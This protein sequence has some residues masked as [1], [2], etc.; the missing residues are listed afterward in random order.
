MHY[1]IEKLAKGGTGICRTEGKTWFVEGALPGEQGEAQ[2]LDDKGRYGRCRAISR[3][4]DSPF[5]NQHD[6]CPL[7]CENKCDGCGFRHVRPE[8]A[9]SLKA[10][11]VYETLIHSARL[12]EMPY[13]C[14]GLDQN[15]L[16]HARTRA[17][18]HIDH[19]RMGF[20]LRESHTVVSASSCE[21]IAPPLRQIIEQLES[22]LKPHPDWRLDIQLDLDDQNRAFAHFKPVDPMP[23]QNRR[24]GKHA[25]PRPPEIP[26]KALGQWAVSAIDH[27]LF[28]GIRIGKTQFYGEPFI[29]DIIRTESGNETVCYRQIGDFAQATRQANAWIHQQV[30]AFVSHYQPQTVAD[31]FS[32]SGNLSFRAAYHAPVVDAYEFYCSQQAFDRGVCEN[33]KRWPENH[34]V[35]LHLHDLSRNLPPKAAQAD[36]IICDPAR[37][38][39]SEKLT[40]DLCLA[41]AKAILYVSCEA[42]CLARDLVRLSGTWKPRKLVFIDMFP[43]TPHI[44][45]VVLL[46]R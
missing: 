45:T 46:S 15:D 14:L 22:Q 11:A 3:E 36:L 31:L 32:G 12:P 10:R 4:N 29:R 26:V 7:S 19:G 28:A 35:S 6:L 23:A 17:R 40:S 30:E 43:Q 5:R 41:K 1:S 8:N 39:L 33:Q 9:L 37:D 25:S 24:P 16:D 2:I 13:T 38:G 20:Y 18:L 44:E 34:R 42:S 27:H 21:V